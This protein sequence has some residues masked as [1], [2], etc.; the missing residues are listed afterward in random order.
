MPSTKCPYF[1]TVAFAESHG[2]YQWAQCVWHGGLGRFRRYSG[3][4]TVE[5][6]G[7]LSPFQFSRLIAMRRQQS[8]TVR[9]FIRAVTSNGLKSRLIQNYRSSSEVPMFRA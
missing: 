5:Y 1:V 7:S 8:G 2:H 4:V 3:N 9:H 6:W